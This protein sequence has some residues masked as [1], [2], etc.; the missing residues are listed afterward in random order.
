MGIRSILEFV[1]EPA[2]QGKALEK[3][4]LD[5]I[6]SA[7]D[8]ANRMLSLINDMLDL[9]KFEAGKINLHRESLNIRDLIEFTFRHMAIQFRQ[10]EIDL[11]MSL[12]DT[13]PPA[14]ADPQKLSQVITNLLSNALKFTPPRG[15]I[16]LST[17][18]LQSTNPAVPEPMIQVAIS[19]EGPG[20]LPEELPALFER[21]KQVSS[22]KSVKEKGTGL[23]LAICKMIVEAHGGQITAESEPGKVTTFRFTLPTKLPTT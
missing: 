10:K 3:N 13:V 6:V 2:M 22:A 18:L 12:D 21:Y 20:I 7:H 9:S 23:G 16:T 15:V 19:N 5:L 14:V 8:A 1:R 4:H 11:R 17:H